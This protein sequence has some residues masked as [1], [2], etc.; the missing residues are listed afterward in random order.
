MDRRGRL[1]VAVE[2][3]NVRAGIA[4]ER[5]IPCDSLWTNQGQICAFER[6]LSRILAHSS[7][8]SSRILAHS[9]IESKSSA[10]LRRTTVL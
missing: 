9:S 8:E 4:V 6:D 1:A 2:Q 7:I 10:E 3:S 5:A